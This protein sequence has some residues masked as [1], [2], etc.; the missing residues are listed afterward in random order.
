MQSLHATG[1]L[2]TGC[3]EYISVK[4][5][6]ATIIIKAVFIVKLVIKSM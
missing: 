4:K 1:I 6:M 3:F 5:I 2:N